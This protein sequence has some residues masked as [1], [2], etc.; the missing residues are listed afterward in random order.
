MRIDMR[1]VLRDCFQVQAVLTTLDVK[2]SQRIWWSELDVRALW[3]LEQVRACGELACR[4][5][6]TH[7]HLC[8]LAH[9]QYPCERDDW[10]LESFVRAIMD[11]R[12]VPEGESSRRHKDEKCARMLVHHKVSAHGKSRRAGLSMA[13]AEVVQDVDDPGADKQEDKVQWAADM[14]RQSTLAGLGGLNGR[15]DESDNRQAE[16][17]AWQRR[18]TTAIIAEAEGLPWLRESTR[19]HM[20]TKER[21]L[22]E[23][24]GLAAVILARS[25]AG[26][27]HPIAGLPPAKA[28]AV[29]GAVK[30]RV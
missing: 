15:E 24:K 13:F 5:T 20:L 29:N 27:P 17:G 6:K 1:R 14:K 2:H 23:E 26:L 19:E 11:R 25:M 4:D 21:E 30:I 8:C 28:K 10:D 3:T 18:P 16:E 7:W 9:S 12:L 22:K